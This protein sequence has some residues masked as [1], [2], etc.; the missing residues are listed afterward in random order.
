VSQ[1]LNRGATRRTLSRRTLLGGATTLGVAAVLPLSATSSAQAGTAARSDVFSLGV[2]SGDPL[3]DRVIIWTRLAAVPTAPDGGLP[4]R[5]I[6]VEW[7]VALDER[8]HN[9]VR[10]G[11][12]HADPALGHSVHVDVTGLSEGG[13][14]FYRFRALGQLSPVGR[15]RTAPAPDAAAPRLRLATGNCQ[16]FQNGYYSAQAALAAEDIDLVVFLGDYIYEYDPHSAFPDRLHTQTEAFQA[17]N[18]RG[19]LSTLGDYRARYGLYKSDPALQAAHL[20]APWISIWSDHE[21][22]NNYADLVDEVDDRPGTPE[23][24]TPEQFAAQRANGYQAWYE[25]TPVRVDPSQVGTP[26]LRIYRD[27]SWGRLARLYCLDTRQYR[28]EQPGHP[29]TSQDVGPA[30]LG[31]ANTGGSLYGAE[32]EAWLTGALGRSD[33]TWDILLNEVMVGRFRFP[34]PADVPAI[35]AGQKPLPP[36]EQALANL[37]EWDGYSAYRRRIL[38]LLATR[39]SPVVLSGDIHSSWVNDLRADPDN[40]TTPVVATEFVSASI[41]SAGF[42]QG[43]PDALVRP[44]NAFYNPDARYFQAER[45]GYNLCEVAPDTFTTQVRLVDSI[46]TPTSPVRTAVTF[47]T[48]AGHP[49]AHPA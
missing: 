29:L 4:P 36:P 14:Y 33:A 28:T 25:N 26:N 21:V 31:I 44:L 22:E 12:A 24:Q 19:Q 17:G 47:A 8:F 37:D 35:I 43:L 38:G 15:T 49:G 2:A 10:R 13:W 42:T 16:D 23:H 32:Q 39:P 1:P 40:P 5:I 7:Q 48:E 6:E 18:P 3:P 27:F 41:S 34:N 46:A 45:H 9:V 11:T 20:I 30:V